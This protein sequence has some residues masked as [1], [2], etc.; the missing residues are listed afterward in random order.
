MFHDY[1]IWDKFV[2]ADMA[3]KFL[4]SGVCKNLQKSI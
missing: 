4:M 3:R 2:G 1:L